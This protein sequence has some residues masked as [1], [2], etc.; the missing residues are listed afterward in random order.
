MSSAAG[1]QGYQRPEI[2]EASGSNP[3][4]QVLR[5]GWTDGLSTSSAARPYTYCASKLPPSAGRVDLVRLDLDLSPV[6]D[7]RCD[8]VYLYAYGLRSY[9]WRERAV[10]VI[11]LAKWMT[12]SKS[13][14]RHTTI[15]RHL[16]SL[17]LPWMLSSIMRPW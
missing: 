8:R 10:K 17:F 9:H 16:P 3:R 2:G 7:V 4:V 15:S 5:H 12:I 13:N 14:K 6:R 1:A 11:V